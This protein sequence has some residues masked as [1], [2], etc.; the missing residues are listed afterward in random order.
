[1]RWWILGIAALS[2]LMVAAATDQYGAASWRILKSLLTTLDCPGGVCDLA[3]G[4]TV[5]GSPIGGGGGVSDGDK[6]DVVVSGGG[7]TWL[8]DDN[9][10]VTGWQLGTLGGNLNL[11]NFN[12][13][14]IGN[15]TSTP[16]VDTSSW[17]AP[18][19]PA[20]I[21]ATSYF[22]IDGSKNLCTDS[23]S[24]GGPPQT[25]GSP[26][27]LC[28]SDGVTKAG[29]TRIYGSKSTL[30]SLTE[31]E[32]YGDFQTVIS[33]GDMDVVAR[34]SDVYCTGG[35]QDEG[36]EGCQSLRNVAQDFYYA[37]DGNIS[38]TLGSGSGTTSVAVTNLSATES[39]LVGENKLLVFTTNA[40]AGAVSQSVDIVALPPGTIN[41][42]GSETAGWT[43]GA[44]TWNI[45]NGVVAS[46]GVGDGWC[47]AS[48]DSA[49]TDASSVS[50]YQWLKITSSGA[51]DGTMDTIVTEAMIQG[52]DHGLPRGYLASTGSS[53]GFISPCVEIDQPTLNSSKIATSISVRRAAGFDGTGNNEDFVVSPYPNHR[54]VGARFLI[55]QAQG[56]G[57]RAIGVQSINRLETN[58]SRYQGFAAFQPTKAGSTSNLKDGKKH[59]WLYGIYCATGD[60]ESGYRYDYVDIASNNSWPIEL[61]MPTA[62]WTTSP[63]TFVVARTNDDSTKNLTL[64]PTNGWGAN[65]DW[66]LRNSLIGS[67]VQAFDADLSDLADGVLTFSKIGGASASKCARFDGSGNLVAAS[68]DCASGDTS[69]GGNSVEVSMAITSDGSFFSTAVTGQTWVASGSEIVCAPFGTTADGL[70]PEAVTI[71]A[72]D[73]SVSD[74]VAGDGFTLNV[75]SP[76]GLEGTVRAH[77]IGV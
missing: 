1:M 60:C 44:K 23:F 68:G 48:T 36:D 59:S 40:S 71:G 45:T 17:T 76:N 34:E 69:G 50:H 62:R 14:N 35:S 77:C 63:E 24:T 15:T 53:K 29:K 3:A 58:R 30:I 9:A 21:D 47:F 31:S 22:A 16:P 57:L 27:G 7:A 52:V 18:L 49:Y 28:D 56:A 39:Q 11:G 5:G 33:G 55:S 37:V 12:I 61:D 6:G 46:S 2:L 66:F 65:G 43:T 41:S 64:H 32:A 25:S 73:F 70:T 51:G 42:S 74:K 4:T 54:L 26:D 67:I 19:G 75:Y 13:L 20:A 38:G 72:L 8:A 10:I